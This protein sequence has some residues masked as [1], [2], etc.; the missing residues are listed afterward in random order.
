MPSHLQR[1]FDLDLPPSPY[2]LITHAGAACPPPALKRRLHEWAGVDAVWEF[3]GSTEVSSLCSAADWEQRP[4]T[5]GRARAGRRLEVPR[6]RDLVSHPEFARF[7]YWND[8][9]KTAAA[10]DGDAFSVGDL[11]RLDDGFLYLEGRRGTS[12]S[13]VV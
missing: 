8:D 4:G 1:L 12:S 3:Y 6:R 5:V 2:R 7:S 11:G 13:V 9:A 10:W